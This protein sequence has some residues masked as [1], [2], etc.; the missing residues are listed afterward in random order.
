MHV[1]RIHIALFLLTGFL[2]PQAA[3]S[4]HYFIIPH[5]V[6]NADAGEELTLPAYEYHFCDYQ[7]SGWNFFISATGKMNSPHF[8]AK[9][10]KPVFSYCVDLINELAFHYSLRGPP[11]DL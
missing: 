4:V 5:T 7:I 9:G 6:P 8:S 2:F 11:Y 3:N 1:F 10:V